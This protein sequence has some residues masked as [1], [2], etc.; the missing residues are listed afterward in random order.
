[1]PVEFTIGDARLLWHFGDG[2]TG[3]TG[4]AVVRLGWRSPSGALRLRL[5]PFEARRGRRSRAPQPRDWATS[6]SPPA[7]ACLVRDNL[8]P[9]RPDQVSLIFG[10]KVNR[11]TPGHFRTP[12][13]CT[14]S[15]RRSRWSS[16][17]HWRSACPAT[18]QRPGRLPTPARRVL[19]EKPASTPRA[20]A[21]PR[22]R[23]H[24]RPG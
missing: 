17:A 1:M 4:D 20:T 16:A 7:M 15:T 14:G 3:M 18:A 5:G 24:D 22:T 21:G 13:V 9:G 23:R 6:V 8:G 2:P 11:R 19:Q 10:K 12:G